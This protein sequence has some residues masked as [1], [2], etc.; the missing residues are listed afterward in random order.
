MDT[1]VKKMRHLV[2]GELLRVERL[3][4]EGGQLAAAILTNWYSQNFACPEHGAVMELFSTSTLPGACHC[5]GL[6]TLRMISPE[7]GA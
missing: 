2:K 1:A 5:H 3:P 4:R 6:G 7:L